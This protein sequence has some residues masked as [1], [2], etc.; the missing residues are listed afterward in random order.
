MGRDFRASVGKDDVRVAAGELKGQPLRV[1]KRPGTRPTGDKVRDAI[2]NVLG[3]SVVGAR[4]LDL[5]AGT[6]ALAIEALSRGATNAVLVESGREAC[7]TIRANLRTT[8]QDGNATVQ[9]SAVNRYLEKPAGEFDLVLADPPYEDLGIPALMDTLGASAMLAQGA[10]V[11]LE[12][13]KRFE[14]ESEYGKLR[15]RQVKKYG[16]TCVSFFE[17]GDR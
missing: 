13:G 15:R 16:D 10:S 7:E 9:C 4:V 12:H 14:T 8:R 5:Y 1:P 11:V 3:D 2:F 17:A 6:G